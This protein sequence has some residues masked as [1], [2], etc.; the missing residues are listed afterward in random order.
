MGE[1][2]NAAFTTLGCPYDAFL[3][4]SSAF[5]QTPLAKGIY[6]RDKRKMLKSFERGR[7]GE[8]EDSHSEDSERSTGS[9]RSSKGAESSS[10][11]DEEDKEDGSQ[12]D[13]GKSAASPPQAL[14]EQRR[15]TRRCTRWW[16]RRRRGDRRRR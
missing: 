12:Q 2:L 7:L 3:T 16:Q 13:A 11:D 4:R 1:L 8:A 14:A 9:L 10:S 5:S 15:R 6:E